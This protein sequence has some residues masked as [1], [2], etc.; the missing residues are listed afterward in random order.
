[1]PVG[2]INLRGSLPH[3]AINV[4]EPMYRTWTIS[5]ATKVHVHAKTVY[6]LRSYK[7][8][9]SF[10]LSHMQQNDLGKWLLTSRSVLAGICE[11]GVGGGG[12]GGLKG[13]D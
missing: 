11:I 13:C 8:V 9:E 2:Q 3:L 10:W 7:H 12:G 4:L 1:M 5:W 6:M